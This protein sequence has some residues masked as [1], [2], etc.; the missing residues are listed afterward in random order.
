[1]TSSQTTALLLLICG[2]CIGFLIMGGAKGNT[3]LERARAFARTEPLMS[4]AGT[5]PARFRASI[6]KIEQ[7]MREVAVTHEEEQPTSADI[8]PKLFPTDFYRALADTEERRLAFIAQPSMQR[9]RS[10]ERSV[11]RAIHVYRLALERTRHLAERAFADPS[12]RYFFTA[13][14]IGTQNV[15]RKISELTVGITQLQRLH[16]L[17]LRCVR[18]SGHACADAHIREEAVSTSTP[19]TKLPPPPLVFETRSLLEAGVIPEATYATGTPRVV[20]LETIPPCLSFLGTP[21]YAAPYFKI[22]DGETRAFYL[23]P[24]NDLLFWDAGR[25]KE[26]VAIPYFEHMAELGITYSYQPSAHVYLCPDNVSAQASALSMVAIRERLAHEGVLF[27]SETLSPLV[28]A[29]QGQLLY[30]SDVRALIDAL[31]SEHPSLSRKAQESADELIALWSTQSA[32]LDTLFATVAY[33]AESYLR[34]HT[35]GYFRTFSPDY[36][37]VARAPLPLAFLTF[38]Q[39]IAGKQQSQVSEYNVAPLGEFMV[40]Y[41]RELRGR[42]SRSALV[43]LMRNSTWYERGT[44]R[45]P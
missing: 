32:F 17:R 19:P 39:T 41:A 36:S 28:Q 10:Y 12:A 18:G 1:M 4:I 6:E 2:A 14:S 35:L 31:R 20:V 44:P 22:V 25:A 5:D 27:E 33:Q 42:L 26:K 23:H 37:F 45:S 43:E 16:Q 30:E 3:S 38:N 8:L 24:L 21:L 9:F 15:S 34:G 40:L 11:A 13:S 7:V 29:T